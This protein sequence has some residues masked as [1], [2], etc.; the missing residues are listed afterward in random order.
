[1]IR[2][3]GYYFRATWKG[4]EQPYGKLYT[5][6]VAKKTPCLYK[7]IKGCLSTIWVLKIEMQLWHFYHAQKN[8]LNQTER[9]NEEAMNGYFWTS[10]FKSQTTECFPIQQTSLDSFVQP[11]N[12]STTHS[13]LIKS[14]TKVMHTPFNT[15]LAVP[16]SLGYLQKH[17]LDTAC[18]KRSKQYRSCKYMRLTHTG[19]YSVKYTS[20]SE[21]KKFLLY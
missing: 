5:F 6:F 18:F 20:T 21:I 19:W 11:I 9:K 4:R 12:R 7:H 13:C 10:D 14:C 1:M 16:R 2:R 15:D 3:E 17:C 8:Y